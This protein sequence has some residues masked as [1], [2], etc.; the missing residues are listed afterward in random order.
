[1]KRIDQ[2]TFTRFI[3]IIVVLFFHGSGGVYHQILRAYLPP[4]LLVS[5]TTSVTYLYVL[6]GFVMALV[7][8][9]PQ[10][11]FA[12]G[13]YWK[14]RILRLYPLYFISFLLVCYYYIDFIARV[15]PQKILVNVFVLQAWWPPYAQS[16]NYAAWSMTVEF[17]FY[18]LF[19]FFV[20]WAYPQS[21]KKLIWAS[22]ALWVFSQVV[23]NILWI[24][25]FPEEEN[26]L[27]YFPLFH[28]SSFILGAVGGI[29]FLREGRGQLVKPRTSLLVFWG[30]V[31]LTSVYIIVSSKSTHMPNQLELM[32]GLLAPFLAITIAALAL[33]TSR[34]S[35]FFNH[36][37]LVTLGDTSYGLYILHVPFIWIYQRALGNSSL[38]NPQLVFDYTF[39]PLMIGTG[40]LIHFYVD[41]PLRNWLKKILQRV[42]LPLLVL[43]LAIIALSI[44]LSFRL[45]FDVKREYESYRSMALLMFWSAFVLRTVFSVRFNAL[46]PAN[47]YGTLVQFV[48]PVLIS[49]TVGSLVVAGIVLVEYSLGSFENYPR[50]VFAMEW[51]LILG[52]SLGVRFIFRFLGVYKN[53]L[54]LPSLRA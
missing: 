4:A 24:G 46:N 23:H 41:S 39:L 31:F 21:T 35:T 12:V 34:L 18:A 13:K 11:K 30:S 32:T 3:A 37:A 33:D 2:L 51:A 52:L 28:L 54:L 44:Y 53:E 50:S 7:Y 22:I 43:D 8:Y 29:W 42:S 25:Y 40:L 16:F 36:P 49:V 5:A 9:R 10:E 1:M 17:F 48:R 26:F 6:S 19:P 38:A 45:R 14:S 27:V 15:K 20:T 47:F